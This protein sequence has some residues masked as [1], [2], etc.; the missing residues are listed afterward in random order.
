MGGRRAVEGRVE[1]NKYY[2]SVHLGFCLYGPGIELLRLYAGEKEMWSGSVSDTPQPIT[3][4]NLGLFGG[5]KNEGGVQGIAYWLPGSPIQTLVNALASRMGLRK[6]TC[7]AYRGIASV[8]FL[9]RSRD[10]VPA[11]ADPGD[12]HPDNTTL[13]SQEPRRGFYW[14]AN[15]PYLRNVW[16]RF[17]RAPQGLNPSIAMIDLPPDSKGRPQKA[18]NG[19]HI[20]FECLTNRDWGTGISTGGIDVQSY[21]RAS[22]TIY[23]EGLGLSAA[24]MRQSSIE[25]FIVEILDHIQATQYLDPHTGLLT[26]KLLRDDYDPNDLF[27]INPSNADL[28]NFQRKMWGESANEIVVTYTNPETEKEETIT[29][30]DLGSVAMQGGIINSGRNYYMVRSAETA[31]RLAERDLAASSQPLAVCEVEVSREGWDLVTGQV[32]ALE[33]PE[34]GIDRAIMR[35]GKVDYGGPRSDRVKV[36]LFEDV[37]GLAR[38]SYL[39]S[40]SSEWTS[41]SVDPENVPFRIVT[42]P[43]QLLSFILE[44][45]P[46]DMIEYP[47]AMPMFMVGPENRDYVNYELLASSPVVGNGGM[48]MTSL[49]TKSFPWGVIELEED[50]P[51]DADVLHG[52]YSVKFGGLPFVGQFLFFDGGSEDQDEIAHISTGGG[53]SPDLPDDGGLPAVPIIR[54]LDDTVPK[55]W[56]AGTKVYVFD[57]DSAFPDQ[58]IRAIGEEVDYRILTRTSRGSLSVEDATPITVELSN[59][60]ELPVRPREVTAGGE[61]YELDATGLSTIDVAWKIRNRATHWNIIVPFHSPVE[62]SYPV[63]QPEAGQVTT[64]EVLSDSGDVIQTYTEAAATQLSVPVSAFGANSSGWIRVGSERDGLSS[65]QSHSIRVTNIGL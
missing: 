64:V 39:G 46:G 14:T 24:W 31:T 37:F 23:E 30:Q 18:A 5:Q 26:L 36:E 60:T 15:Q 51:R 16:A 42:A 49:G 11:P 2:L 19:V 61:R 45:D 32:V 34:H 33:W 50:L 8:F 21:E 53:P 44:L 52:K 43:V 40:Q 58:Q 22:Q 1:V 28:S 57:F 20:V 25:E 59:R 56:P 13:N 27:V 35:V 65:L 4:N 54:G 10:G 63:E 41:P 17:R 12:W 29:A 47:N 3:I 6:H 7:P 9:G 48:V 38:S 62:T 55:T